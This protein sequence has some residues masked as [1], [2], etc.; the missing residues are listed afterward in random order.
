MAPHKPT[1]IPSPNWDI[2]ANDELVVLGRLIKDPTNPHSKIARSGVG[3]IPP[4]AIREKQDEN[5]ETTFEQ[6]CS[7]SLGVWAKCLLLVQCGSDLKQV[8]SS[9]ERHKFK[10]LETRYFVPD[11]EYLERALG[12]PGVQAFL[13]VKNWRAPV[14][15]ITG[16]K[17]ARGASVSAES[18]SGRSARAELKVD[19]TGAGVPVEVGPEAG[20]GS[21]SKRGISFTGSTDY[22]FAYQL[23]RMKPKKRSGTSENKSYVKG[24][25]FGTGEDGGA[26]EASVLD[27]FDIEEETGGQGIRD[28]LE[29]VD[30]DGA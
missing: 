17:I 7:G 29:Q 4:S 2:P 19:G 6:V 28:E 25:V 27:K 24:A 15:M 9:A 26:D 10:V 1:Y 5:F 11:E 13:H 22:I 3:A 14:Y 16:I 20:W 18:S 12:D 8:R 30:V 23:T 21:G